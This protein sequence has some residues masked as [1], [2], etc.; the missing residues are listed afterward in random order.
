MSRYIQEKSQTVAPA[1]RNEDDLRGWVSDESARTSKGTAS[2]VQ[3]RFNHLPPGMNNEAQATADIRHMGSTTAGSMPRDGASGDYTQP[4]T[5][6]SIR[7]GFD[8]LPMLATDGDANEP[9]YREITV[10][11]VTAVNERGNVLDRN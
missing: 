7:N 8:R 11:G 5:R 9:F 2:G 1:N 10:D 3:A 4:V 6:E